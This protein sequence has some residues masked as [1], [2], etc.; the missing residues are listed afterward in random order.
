LHILLENLVRR[1]PE[2]EQC[3]TDIQR[4]TR[5]LEHSFRHGGKLLICGNGGSASDSE[6]I[7]AELMKSFRLPR[8]LP[9]TLREALIETFPAEGAYLADH[10]QEALP[11]IPLVSNG[12]LLTA[13]GNDIDADM[14]FAQ[15]VC[16]YGQAGDVL[17][18][19]ST[20]GTSRNVRYALQVACVLGLRTLGLTGMSG[21]VLPELCDVTIR[22][23]ADTTAEVQELHIPVY[24]VI[25]SLL[26][27]TFYAERMDHS[28]ALHLKKLVSLH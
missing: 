15:Q 7:A 8:P 5:L 28:Y 12:A 3:L 17:M 11:A 18:G 19:I 16:G 13:T 20:S 6:H 1:Y 26:E 25:C 9:D 4:G 22:V 14:I 2:L 21:G 24:H 10:L 27:E 23:P